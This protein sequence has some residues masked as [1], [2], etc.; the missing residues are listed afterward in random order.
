MPLRVPVNPIYFPLLLAEPPS[1]PPT[2]TITASLQLTE[3]PSKWKGLYALG[4]GLILL[5]W[6][7]KVF[8]NLAFL[9]GRYPPRKGLAEEGNASTMSLN[10]A[11]DSGS[12][13][14][15]KGSAV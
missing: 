2:L 9:K 15:P 3:Q 10:G 11:S 1:H 4:F 6:A 14:R 8:Y 5:L 7:G 13:S 12:S